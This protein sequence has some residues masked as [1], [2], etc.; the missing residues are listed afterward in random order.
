MKITIKV[1]PNSSKSEIQQIN[2][3][4]YKVF[5][6]KPNQ[7]GKANQELEKLLK[8]HFKQSIKILKGK[9]SK[10]KLVELY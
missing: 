3:T 1:Q 2:E 7:K 10:T 8:K 9:T 4:T 6:R 5:L